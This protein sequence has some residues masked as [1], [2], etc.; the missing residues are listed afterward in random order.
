MSFKVS[1]QDYLT[2]PAIRPVTIAPRSAAAIPLRVV[3]PAQT[4]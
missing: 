2:V 1:G 4:G 3:M